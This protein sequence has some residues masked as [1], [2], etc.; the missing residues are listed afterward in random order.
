MTLTEYLEQASLTRSQFAERINVTTEAVRRYVEGERVPNRRIM[1]RILL[2]TAG[3]VTPN[4]FFR[5]AA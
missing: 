5:V 3:Q 4:D 1:A 2:E